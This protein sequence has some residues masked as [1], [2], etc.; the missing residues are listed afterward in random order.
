M[1]RVFKEPLL[2][3]RNRGADQDD[4]LSIID[5]PEFKKPRLDWSYSTRKKMLLLKHDPSQTTITDYYDIA[6]Q[7][8]L[9]AKSK[10]ELMNAL[11]HANNEFK[12]ACAKQTNFQSFF[13]QII[14]NAEKNAE[15][16]PHAR[17][18]T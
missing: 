12:Q 9:L 5:A 2:L 4:Q 8:D 13:Q 1:M 16:L 18:H 10:P 6:N 15:K 14:A 3:Q 11:H 7:I 17:R